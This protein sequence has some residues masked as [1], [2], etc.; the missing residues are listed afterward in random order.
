MLGRLSLTAR[1]TVFYALVSAAVLVGLAI[2]VAFATSRHFV[3]LD[4][5]YLRDKIQLVQKIVG[6]SPSPEQLS[7]RL[8]ELLGSHHALHRPAPR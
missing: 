8:D 6:E 5:D 4:R 7:S 2:L 3:E 1:L